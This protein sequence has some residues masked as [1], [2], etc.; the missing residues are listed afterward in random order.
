[1][2]KT[3]YEFIRFAEQPKPEARKTAI[4]SCINVHHGDMLGQIAWLGARR[5]YVFCPIGG[6]VYSAGC[7]A[8]V[9]DFIEQLMKQRRAKRLM[10]DV[11]GMETP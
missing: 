1:M 9:Q 5:Q 7:L 2:L 6:T 4:W 8:D 10:A 11:L 3:E